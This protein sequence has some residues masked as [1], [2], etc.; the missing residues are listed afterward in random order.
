MNFAR[1]TTHKNDLG[2]NILLNFVMMIQVAVVEM[3]IPLS[4]IN[5]GLIISALFQA[6]ICW[7]MHV[8]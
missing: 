1:Q 7:P 6:L 3:E 4:G 8:L 5:T 2:F